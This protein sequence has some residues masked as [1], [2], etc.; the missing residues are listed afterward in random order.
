MKTLTLHRRHIKG[1]SENRIAIYVNGKKVARLKDN[2]TQVVTIQEEIVEIQAK[3]LNWF[4]SEKIKIDLKEYNKIDIIPTTNTYNHYVI[5]LSPA[6]IGLSTLC[7][8]FYQLPAYLISLLV[9]GIYAHAIYFRRNTWF[10]I[11]PQ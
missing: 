9:I 10:K 2:E 6:I 7:Y 8:K 4:G 5:I 11:D 1:Y 3:S